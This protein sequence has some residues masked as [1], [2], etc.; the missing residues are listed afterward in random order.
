MH[1]RRTNSGS[2]A[3]VVILSKIICALILMGLVWL[4]N[5]SYSIKPMG[6]WYYLWLFFIFF[7]FSCGVAVADN[8]QIGRNDNYGYGYQYNYQ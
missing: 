2:F 6:S 7:F 5:W 1:Y 4:L 8:K 3:T